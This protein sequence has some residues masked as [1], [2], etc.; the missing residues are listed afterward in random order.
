MDSDEA[1]VTARSHASI[2]RSNTDRAEGSSQ[3]HQPDYTLRSY[4][5]EGLSAV[6]ER[7]Q[8]HHNDGERRHASNEFNLS[9]LRA[10]MQE[11]RA[12]T[13]ERV[14]K[15]EGDKAWEAHERRQLAARHGFSESQIFEMDLATYERTKLERKSRQKTEQEVV[16]RKME[17]AITDDGQRSPDLVIRETKL[18]IGIRL[19]HLVEFL[20]ADNAANKVKKHSLDL[21]SDE[22]TWNKF[23]L[24]YAIRLVAKGN[25]NLTAKGIDIAESFQTL[26]EALAK[27]KA[28]ADSAKNTVDWHGAVTDLEQSSTQL[29]DLC[30]AFQRQRYPAGVIGD[31][32]G[33]TSTPVTGTQVTTRVQSSHATT[34]DASSP[35]PSD[36]GDEES[37][38]SN[39]E[40]IPTNEPSAGESTDSVAPSTPAEHQYLKSQALLRQYRDP[41]GPRSYILARYVK[42]GR[43]RKQRRDA[44]LGADKRPVY[45]SD[46]ETDA[47]VFRYPHMYWAKMDYSIS[48]WTE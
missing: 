14:I 9:R 26:F 42:R 17:A 33:E 28:L 12:E 48:P 45:T 5:R 37:E 7:L 31:H 24:L 40:G 6:S 34:P 19:H 38:A 43:R 46:P 27:I 10:K 36:G 25:A 4:L 18:D 30:E 21:P 29:Q 44:G 22:L 15:V 32:S 3:R 47:I 8:G 1:P 39:H 13:L 23:V 11:I 20:S 16:H 41:R 2:G 35:V